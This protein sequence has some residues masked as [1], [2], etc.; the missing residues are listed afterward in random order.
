MENMNKIHIHNIAA[1][2]VEHFEDILI[3]NK[4]FIPSPEDR[5]NKRDKDDYGLYGSVYSELLDN[6]ENAL[7][8]LLDNYTKLIAAHSREL[9][10]S[11]GEFYDE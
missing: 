8:E 1:D 2:F 3:A 9:F 4:V 6:V 11:D 7:I 10:V 5:E